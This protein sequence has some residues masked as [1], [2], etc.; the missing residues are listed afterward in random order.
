MQNTI[1]LKYNGQEV[2]SKPFTFGI[3]CIIDD[4]QYDGGGI[5]T[6]TGK[7]LIKMFEG[8]VITEEVIEGLKVPLNELKE[9]R[10]KVLRIYLDSLEE[11][12]NE[13]SPL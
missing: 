2:I 11:L 9:A 12:K 8:T 10:S 7:A 4:G 3:A 6:G 5:A 13:E 1:T